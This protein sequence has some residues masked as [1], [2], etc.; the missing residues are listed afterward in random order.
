MRRLAGVGLGLALACSASAQVSTSLDGAFRSFHYYGLFP[1]P[2]TKSSNPLDQSGF[3]ARLPEQTPMTGGIPEQDNNYHLHSDSSSGTYPLVHAEGNVVGEYKGYRMQ[4]DVLDGNRDTQVFII[5]GNA[6]LTGPDAIVQARRIIVDYRHRTYEAYGDDS[7]IRPTL[8]GGI[9][10]TDVYAKSQHSN[11]SEK[12]DFLQHAEITTCNYPEP[13]YTLDARDIDLRF[14]KRII[15]RDLSVW[16]L[17]HHLFNLPFLSIPL[18]DRHYQN[19]PVVGEDS[20]EGYYIKTNYGIPLRGDATLFTRLDYM[21]KLGAGGG[22]N[23]TVAHNSPSGNYKSNITVYG[24]TGI[25]MLDIQQTHDQTFKWGTLHVQNSYNGHDYL[26]APDNDILNSQATLSLNNRRGQT[27]FSFS[28]ASNTAPGFD[29][30]QQT[31]G[32]SNNETIG[33]A[34]KETTQITYTDSANSYASGATQTT[35][36]SKIINVNFNATED[37]R[38]AEA[39][40]AYVRSIPSSEPTGSRF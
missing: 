3:D 4:G 39:T 32:L 30:L 27:S 12:E 24:V 35:S 14:N 23:Y 38:K 21:T 16:I 18:D 9:L 15:F 19:L 10:Q 5:S 37:L 31:F 7:Q 22:V 2:S 20:Y 26:T 34:F 11:G 8:V 28:R 17:G 36:D 25:Q 33:T 6:V 1:G 13:H 40:L 29:S